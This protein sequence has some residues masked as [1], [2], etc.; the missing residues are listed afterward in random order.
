[1]FKAKQ[2]MPI[3]NKRRIIMNTLKWIRRNIRHRQSVRYLAMQR[4]EIDIE[5]PSNNP[6]S[7]V[8]IATIW[9]FPRLPV[10][11]RRVLPLNSGVCTFDHTVG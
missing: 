9:S 1:L 3:R 10:K 8:S 4:V 2:M 6:E 7:A 5:P 11:A